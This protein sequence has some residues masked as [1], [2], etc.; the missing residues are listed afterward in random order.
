MT[1]AAEFD[2]NLANPVQPHI[3]VTPTDVGV[4]A[5]MEV[6]PEFGGLIAADQRLTVS[7]GQL[8]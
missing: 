8:Q 5:A 1:V 6:H 7:F 3:Q 4:V 2:F